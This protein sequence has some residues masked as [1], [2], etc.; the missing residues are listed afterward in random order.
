MANDGIRLFRTLAHPCGYF[1]DRMAIN[2]VLDPESPQLAQFYARALAHGFRR[3]GDAIYRPHCHTCSACV[4]YRIPI[5]DFRADRAQR[6]TLARNQDI[7]V[8]WR[9]AE[10]C[11]EHFGLYR[12]Y[13]AERHT[14]GGMDHPSLDDYQRFLL[15]HWANT[16]FMELRLQ[17]ELVGAAVTDIVA[18]AASAVY[19]YFDPQHAKRS[20]GTLAILKQ[21]EHCRSLALPHLYLGF[22]I[23][24]HPKMHYK[25]NLKPGQIRDESGW[26]AADSENTPPI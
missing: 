21:I 19:T 12:R 16:W 4:P 6:R 1:S 13:L 5:A 11:E 26:K 15:S 25:Q 20:L 2:Q 7:A 22:W 18:D 3:A 14:G 9:T 17:G 24:G 10:P 8:H 23:E